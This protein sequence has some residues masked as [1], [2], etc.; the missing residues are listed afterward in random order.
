MVTTPVRPD[1]P[2]ASGESSATEGSSGGEGTAQGGSPGDPPGRPTRPPGP[3]TPRRIVVGLAVWLVVTAATCALV[4]YGVG[5]MLEV[6]SQRSLLTDYRVEIDQAAN[7]FNSTVEAEDTIEAPEP[8]T[9]VAILDVGDMQ[10]EQVVVEGV[11]P[12]QTR[13]GPG[14]VPGTAA[15]GQPG[16]SAIVARH[17][18]FGG[19]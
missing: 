15:P 1:H 11:G 10:M 3:V 2:G 6:R 4:L 14:H 19:G 5:P 12:Q 16:N 7:S 17:G 13:R 9:P 8:G 18:T